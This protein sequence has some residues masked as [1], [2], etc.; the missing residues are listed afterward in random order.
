M[1]EFKAIKKSVRMSPRK[2]RLVADLIRG[3][4]VGEAIAILKNT[5]STVTEPILKTL[6]SAIANADYAATNNN[7]TVNM[8]DLF[9]KEI[10][11]DGGAM[12]KRMRPRAKGSGAR[13]LKHTS[14]ATIVVADAK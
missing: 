2:A 11:I 7:V 10:Y 9:V 8:N 6:N 13:I 12:L 4:K 3:K 1:A 14:H 5:E